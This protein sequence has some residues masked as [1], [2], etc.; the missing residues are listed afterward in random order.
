MNTQEAESYVKKFEAK[1]DEMDAEAAQWEAKKRAH[2]E[3]ERDNIRGQLSAWRDYTEAK[4]DEFTANIDQAWHGLEAKWHD[5][6]KKDPDE[7]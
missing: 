1:L 6:T 7:E 4:W 5:W 2:Y 3:A